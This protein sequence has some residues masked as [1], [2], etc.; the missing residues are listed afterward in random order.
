MSTHFHKGQSA[1]SS[2]VLLIAHI[3]KWEPCTVLSLLS[4]MQSVVQQGGGTR[5]GC[6]KQSGETTYPAMDSRGGGPV[7]V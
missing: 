7:E 5:Y 6:H 1:F 3:V 2:Y 4:H